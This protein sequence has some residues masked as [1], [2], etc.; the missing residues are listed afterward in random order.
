MLIN[1]GDNH[2]G[3]GRNRIFRRSIET[4]VAPFDEFA[5]DRVP[6][7]VKIDVQGWELEVLRGMTRV[8][9]CNP[10]LRLFLSIGLKA[11]VELVTW[12]MTSSGFSTSE[13]S[14]SI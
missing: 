9:E 3:E 13:I 8:L 6:D 7:L 1:A 14:N 5:L 11:C 10:V 12:L 4:R 2:L